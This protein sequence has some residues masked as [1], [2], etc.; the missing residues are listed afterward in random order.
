MKVRLSKK[1]QTEVA[2]LMVDWTQKMRRA[3]ERIG[4][5]PEARLKWVFEFAKGN[6]SLAQ[7]EERAALGYDLRALHRAG[8]W[9]APY[10]S[11]PVMPDWLV[12]KIHWAIRNGLDAL[13]SARP[14]NEWNFPPPKKISLHRVNPLTSKQTR[15]QHYYQGDEKAAILGGVHDLLVECQQNV[16]VCARC[17]QPFIRIRKQTF[18]SGECSQAERNDRKKSKLQ[19]PQEKR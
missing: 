16:R 13:F 14:D 4:K 19:A 18:C 3:D 12:R 5:T 9:H 1:N 11:G 7:P 6:L 2:Q 10:L 8:D 15:F 17:R